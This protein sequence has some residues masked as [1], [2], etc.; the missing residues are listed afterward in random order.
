MIVERTSGIAS[1]QALSVWI[2]LDASTS[3]RA[4]GISLVPGCYPV[5]GKKFNFLEAGGL[6]GRRIAGGESG[7]MAVHCVFQSGANK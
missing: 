6:G 3:R 1:K 4:T 7:S 2:P 5:D